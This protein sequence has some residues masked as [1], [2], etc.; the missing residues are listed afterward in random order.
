MRGETVRYD[1]RLIE[2]A[3]LLGLRGHPESNRFYRER[4]RLYEIENPEE[5]ER[6]F[7]QLDR[8]WFIHLRLAEPIEQAID[9]QRSL[10]SSVRYC[11]VAPAGKKGEEE[12]ELFVIPQEGLRGKEQ[13]TVRILL[14]PESFLKPSALLTF[15]RHELLHITDMLDPAFGYQPSLPVG[16]GGPAYD[17]LLRERYRVLWDATID[18]RMVRHR[19][20][21]ESLRSQHLDHFGRTFPMLGEQMEQHFS[22]FFDIEPHTHD[23]L[24]AFALNPSAPTLAGTSKFHPGGR[25]P[26]CR[27]P[28]HAF[29]P[30]PEALDGNVVDEINRDFP[31][32]QPSLGLCRQCA[33][34]YRARR[35]SLAAAAQLPGTHFHP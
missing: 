33:D 27:F 17:A 20:L 24:V 30:D 26:L 31:D 19:W 3:V 35:L 29:E 4:N 6:D 11:L 8:S 34:L 1:P 21:P 16:E 28:T 10:E 12:A 18:G 9:E 23:E 7:Q 25:C 32:W 13:P 5:R 15:L 22:R 2:E 14:R